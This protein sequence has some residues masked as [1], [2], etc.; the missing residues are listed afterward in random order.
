MAVGDDRRR[1]KGT[2]VD[3]ASAEANGKLAGGGPVGRQHHRRPH[4]TTAVLVAVLFLTSTAA[5]AIGSSLLASHFS[6]DS[7]GTS[8][9]LAGVLLEAYTGLA[10]VGIG[11]AMLPLLRPANVRLARAYL[12]LRV[13]EC[14]AIVTAGVYMLA[15]NR[16]P[17]HDDLLIYSFTAVGGIIF[18]YLLSASGLVPRLLSVL[19]MVGYVVLLVGI[20]TALA[21]FADLGTGWGVIFLVPGGLFELILPMLLLVKGFSVGTAVDR[22]QPCMTRTPGT[23]PGGSLRRAAIVAGLGLLVMFLLAFAS[24]SAFQGLIEEGDPAT[25]ARNIA[26]H[27]LLVRLIT[28]SFVIVAGLDVLVAWALYVLLRPVNPTIAVLSAWLRVVYAAVFAGALSNLLVAV[29]LT[30]DNALNATQ[31]LMS[32]NQFKDGW[33]LALVIFGFHL[34]VLGYLVFTSNYIPRILG[35]LVAIASLGYLIDSFGG[36]LSSSYDAN[37]A[38]FTFPGEVLLM[39]WLLWRGRRL[40]GP[41]IPTRL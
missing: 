25:T 30:D 13:L 17:Q 4:R 26:D 14:L 41:A 16:E 28:G 5:F 7:P 36:L 10:V 32:V 40:Q 37:V 34:L 33:D 38:S 15:T 2:K 12:G 19:G 24:F 27:E 11:L 39:G 6:G 23:P 35:I 21:G 1:V 31:A 3:T 29:R 22:T 8:T 18:S 20:P 9:L